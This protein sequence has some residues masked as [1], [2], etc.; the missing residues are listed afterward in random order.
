MDCVWY[1]GCGAKWKIFCWTSNFDEKQS[2][3]HFLAFEQAKRAFKAR[4]HS[5]LNSVEFFFHSFCRGA[6]HLGVRWHATRVFYERILWPNNAIV[7]FSFTMIWWPSSSSLSC[8][9]TISMILGCKFIV[10]LVRMKS[11]NEMTEQT[12]IC[13]KIIIYLNI[14]AVCRF[15][16]RIILYRIKKVQ[17]CIWRS[18]V[19]VNIGDKNRMIKTYLNE[20]RNYDNVIIH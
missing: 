13:I 14:F 3:C 8:M 15:F 17:N 10:F 1:R 4:I 6:G 20:K 12:R 11:E 7:L 2:K 5:I 18:M 19:P 9:W 16:I